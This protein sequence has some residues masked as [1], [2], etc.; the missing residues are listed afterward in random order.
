M[1]TVRAGNYE[2][3][4]GDIDGA[5]WGFG[6][7]LPIGRVAGLR[8]DQARVPQAQ[9]LDEVVRHAG[10]VWFDPFELARA[11]SDRSTQLARR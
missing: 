8:Y 7:A 6:I 9:P 10:A 3:R 2:D 1:L 5:T 11:L 4:E